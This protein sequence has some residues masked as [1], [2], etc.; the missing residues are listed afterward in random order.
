MQEKQ[1]EIQQFICHT[2]G[3]LTVEAKNPEEARDKAWKDMGRHHE[4]QAVDAVEPYQRDGNI[5]TIQLNHCGS[6]LASG[7]YK[8]W[9]SKSA[10]WLAFRAVNAMSKDFAGDHSASFQFDLATTLLAHL[11][12]E[13]IAKDK[14]WDRVQELREQKTKGKEKGDGNRYIKEQYAI[15]GSEFDNQSSLDEFEEDSG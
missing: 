6:N 10:M 4:V 9:E 3:S 14:V 13:L 15:E 7:G 5:F 12:G 2:T 1:E 11:E 8:M